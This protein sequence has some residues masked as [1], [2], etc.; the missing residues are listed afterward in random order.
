MNNQDRIAIFD[1][2]SS[3]TFTI[4]PKSIPDPRYISEKLGECH[5]SIEE[6][7]K[8]YINVSKELS[9]LQRAL[10]DAEAAYEHAKNDLL[11]NDPETAG[12]LSI[13]DRE[14]K[15]N[16]KLKAELNDIRNYKNEVED[17]K[18][19]L[20]VINLKLRNLS[21]SNMDIKTQLRLME[22]QIKLGTSMVTDEATKNLMEELSKSDMFQNA[23]TKM[24][25][26]LIQDPTQPI[27]VDKLLAPTQINNL[28]ISEPGTV[29]GTTGIQGTRIDQPVNGLTKE[30]I[31]EAETE[32]TEEITE[33]EDLLPV[34]GSTAT[35]E[36]TTATIDLNNL[37][38]PVL[39]P[40]AWP[41]PASP[42][43]TE[44][45]SIPKPLNEGGLPALK[46]EVEIKGS[47]TKEPESKSTETKKEGTGFDDLISQYL[48]QFNTPKG[49]S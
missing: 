45:K 1:R 31:E 43:V 21:R 16:T 30:I 48:V 14:A 34:S 39:G 6:V 18:G 32:L 44:Q 5:V 46:V 9:V 19:L 42:I 37:L 20:G 2:L 25:E 7:E 28:P 3:M 4:E 15:A 27:N 40:P 17:L 23:E 35:D 24:E 29:F 47:E 13:K 36:P 41:D 26:S 33:E 12:L 8:F 22:S 11:S 10:N 49:V 38:G